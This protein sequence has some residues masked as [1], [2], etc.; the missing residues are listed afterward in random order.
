MGGRAWEDRICEPRAAPPDGSSLR[1]GPAWPA[2]PGAGV[3]PP[4]IVRPLPASERGGARWDGLPPELNNAGA[5]MGAIIVAP[6]G[7]GKPRKS[8][9]ANAFERI[10]AARAGPRREPSARPRGAPAITCAR[11]R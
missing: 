4:R 8:L 2:A 11:P 5:K 6:Q 10:G 9:P 3:S 7:G 1:C